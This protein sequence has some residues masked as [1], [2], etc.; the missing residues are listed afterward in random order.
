MA[1]NNLEQVPASRLA[2]LKS[3]TM[4]AYLTY[5]K[6]NHTPSDDHACWTNVCTY[7]CKVCMYVW[8][9]ENINMHHNCPMECLY[10]RGLSKSRSFK[11]FRFLVLTMQSSVF[12]TTTIT[13]LNNICYTLVHAFN[14]DA[15]IYIANLYYTF[16][17]YD[18]RLKTQKAYIYI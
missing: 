8:R 14:F 10:I 4:L 1:S 6:S 12:R 18:N 17:A 5:Y 3:Y 9:F 11:W 2:F 13:I 16:D 15:Y 7:A